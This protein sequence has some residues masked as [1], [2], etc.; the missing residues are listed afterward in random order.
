MQ[1]S[2]RAIMTLELNRSGEGTR[3]P[4]KKRT[5]RTALAVAAALLA[6]PVFA[7]TARVRTRAGE[8]SVA[9]ADVVAGKVV[10]PPPTRRGAPHR[11]IG[12]PDLQDVP[13]KEA[14]GGSGEFPDDVAEVKS[15]CGGNLAA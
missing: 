7:G 9:L 13:A 4:G 5:G 8:V 2:K 14:E 1:R 6:V 11:V 15:S 12:W 3:T 10:P